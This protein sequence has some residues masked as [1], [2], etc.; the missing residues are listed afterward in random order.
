VLITEWNQFRNLHLRELKERLRRPILVDLRN[1][2]D[3]ERAA[4]AGF[5]YHAVG[6]P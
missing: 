6:R 1:V 5:E 3:H 4:A 2:Y